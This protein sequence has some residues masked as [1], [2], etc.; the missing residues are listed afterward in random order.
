VLQVGKPRS[1]IRLAFDEFEAIDVSLYRP[2]TV[3]KRET[4]ENRGF[5][6]L[7]T[8][9]KGEEFPDSGGTHA[10]EPGVESFTAVVAN[11]V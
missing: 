2:G 9:G 1:T 7:D 4:R 5:V 10:L 3:G 11:E 8:S 6:P